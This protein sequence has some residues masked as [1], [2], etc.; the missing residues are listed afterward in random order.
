MKAIVY[1]RYGPPNLAFDEAAA[2]S[3]GGTTALAFMRSVRLKAG[4][5]VLVNG[6]SG[7]VGTAA[8]QLARHFGADV[9]GV[10]STANVEL[11]RSLGAHHVID[12]THVDF[13]QSGD[14]FPT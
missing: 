6:A 11:V 9:T 13:T 5:K 2:L 10:C 12:Y 3:F 14:R 4:D 1:E 8:E 7:A